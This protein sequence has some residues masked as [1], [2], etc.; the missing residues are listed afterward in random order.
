MSNPSTPSGHLLQLLPEAV[1]QTDALWQI[2]Y[3]NPAWHTRTG[4]AQ[5]AALGRSLLEF[6]HPDDIG[7]LRA[8]MPVFRLRFANA[9]YHW[10]RLQLHPETDA[11]DRVISRQGVLIEITEV[12]EQVLVEVRQRFL[13]LLETI[14]GVVWEAEIGVGNTFLSPQVERLFGYS[15]EEWRADPG[16]WRA[17]VHPDDLAE[18][19]RIDDAAYNATHSHAYEMS[20]RLI[21]K[22]GRVVWVRDL[23]RAVVEPGRP[24]RMI[25][26][27]IDVT[28]QKNTEL[29]LLR[30]DNRYSL[31]TRGSNDGI[32]DWDLRTDVL[33]V[34][35][36]FHQ[37]VGL[38]DIDHVHDGGWRFLAQLIDPEDRGR[39]Q[40][41]YRSHLA[42]SSPNFSVDFRAI[43]GSGRLLWVNWR[44]L[45][46]FEDGVAVRMAGSL[47]DLAERGSSYDALTN[48][49]GRPLF[50]D[51]LAHVI[52]LHRNAL[53]D[54]DGGPAGEGRTTFAVLLLDLNGFKAVNDSHGHPVGDQLLQQVARRLEACV[55]AVDLVARMSG[56]E[57]NVLLESIDPAEAA[58]RACQIAAA[59]DQPYLI[60]AHTV[61]ISASI[62]LVSSASGLT[63][64]DAY[65]RAADTAM[66]RAKSG[67]LGVC[68][69]A[70]EDA[71]KWLG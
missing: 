55:R 25:G 43:H 36:R 41:A 10:V 35:E 13:R 46:Q 51:R 67:A 15:V 53:A 65:L 45:A 60:D 61:V 28:R 26:L 70:G 44:G 5:E 66:Y 4:H 18:A 39:V 32:W 6:V 52:A 48:L 1:V 19:M 23:C 54:G 50:R 59:L 38:G 12:T 16:F 27:M 11:V 30:S 20:Y 34:S 69:F 37:I 14:D 63:S 22:S 58:D 56:D 9:D 64:I 17:H 31:A 42:G 62:G 2:T 47:S 40:T 21:A 7:T 71:E 68:V 33:H 49:P 8:G 3:L 24:N 29:E 57:F